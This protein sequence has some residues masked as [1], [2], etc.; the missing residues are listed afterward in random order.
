[1]YNNDLQAG[2]LQYVILKLALTFV[3]F[4]LEPF[5]LFGEGEF[6]HKKAWVYISSATNLSQ[7]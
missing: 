5:D 6:T 2:V 1:M 7:M 3:S 4:G